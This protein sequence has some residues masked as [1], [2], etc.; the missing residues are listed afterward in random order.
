[1]MKT[2]ASS[3]EE[4]KGK[5]RSGAIVSASSAAVE[6]GEFLMPEASA[7]RMIETCAAQIEKAIALPDVKRVITQAEAIKV[8]VN[9]LGAS[10]RVKK[11]ALKL[12]VQ[13]EVQ[14]GKV[15][16]ALPVLSPGSNCRFIPK[17]EP[18]KGKNFALKEAGINPARA[19][20]AEKLAEVPPEQLQKTVEACTNLHAVQTAVGIRRPFHGQTAGEK[21]E[22]DLAF[23]ADEAITL[24]ERI[25]TAKMHEGTVREFRSRWRRLTDTSR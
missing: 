19:R 13:A 3:D 12:V 17:S 24:L 8:L 18:R 2:S 4:G 21:R 9:K 25:N 15:S 1:M 7:I 5:K 14:L 22:R 20:H 11:T 23:L 16:K 10:Q 6:A